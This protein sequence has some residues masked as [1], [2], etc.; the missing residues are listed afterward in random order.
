MVGVAEGLDT[1]ALELGGD[2]GEVDPGIRGR[3]KRPF[4]RLGIG[5]ERARHLAMVGECVQL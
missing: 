2:S 1:V 5:V 4:A 3:G